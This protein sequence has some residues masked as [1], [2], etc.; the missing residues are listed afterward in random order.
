MRMAIKR[1]EADFILT[2]ESEDSIH[3][4]LTTM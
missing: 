3:S 4:A 2:I 1:R